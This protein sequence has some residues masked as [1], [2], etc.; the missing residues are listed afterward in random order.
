VGFSGLND[1]I[2]IVL[3]S[4]LSILL[5]LEYSSIMRNVSKVQHECKL[6]GIPHT[7]QTKV[8]IEY[9]RARRL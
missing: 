2:I 7:I 5:T 3:N 6:D 8:K 9:C 4:K 1:N